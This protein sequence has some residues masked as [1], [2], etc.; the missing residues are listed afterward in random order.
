VCLPI[1]G[2]L[3]LANTLVKE[4]NLNSFSEKI[5]G[6]DGSPFFVLVQSCIFLW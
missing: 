6:E 4:L 2:A 3:K 5:V 1:T